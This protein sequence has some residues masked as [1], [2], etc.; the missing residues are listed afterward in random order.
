MSPPI[1]GKMGLK[2]IDTG[3]KGPKEPVPVVPKSSNY[4]YCWGV[5]ACS[6]Y[7]GHKRVIHGCRNL[8]F[9]ICGNLRFDISESDEVKGRY[10]RTGR[11]RV[12][13]GYLDGLLQRNES[14]GWLG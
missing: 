7:W 11:R 4:C 5:C 9:D 1:L 13:G 10:A 3:T 8:R 6:N 2:A 12:R 14:I